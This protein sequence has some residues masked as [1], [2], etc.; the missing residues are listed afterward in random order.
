MMSAGA[1]GPEWP[2]NRENDPVGDE[3]AVPL[4][5]GCTEAGTENEASVSLFG[6]DNSTDTRVSDNVNEFGVLKFENDETSPDDASGG[7]LEN[8]HSHSVS[9]KNGNGE[10]STDARDGKYA[11]KKAK[12]AVAD[13]DLILSE[14]DHFAAKG[15]SEAVG[16]GYEIGDMVWGKVKS[17]PWWPGHIYDEALAS[18]S[19]QRSKREGHVLVA[20]YGDSSYG[21]F[22]LEELV[23][24][25][26][27]FA[28]KSWQTSS[29]AFVKAVEE[30]VDDLS[31]R[32]G[33]GLAC[34]CRNE[35][36]FG[37][38]KK[39]G[40]FVVDV[41]DSEPGVFSLRQIKKARDDFRPKKML[42]YVLQMALTP[43]TDQHW[44]IDFIKNKSTVL[45]C[46]K[47]L[48][49]EFDETYAQ[50]FG[51]VPERP[52]RPTRP[53][54]V[55]P[56]KVS[57]EKCI[58]YYERENWK[59]A[60]YCFEGHMTMHE[61]CG[62]GAAD[63]PLSGRL[64]FADTLGKDKQQFIKPSKTKDQLE[65]DKYLFVRRD[66][67][68]HVNSKKT[69]FSVQSETGGV[70]PFEGPRKSV[71]VQINTKRQIGELSEANVTVKQ[72]KKKKRKIEIQ[73]VGSAK[74]VRTPLATNS[75][76][77]GAVE[78]VSSEKILDDRK[79]DFAVN[80]SISPSEAQKSAI[81]LPFLVRE[82][83]TL[84]LDSRHGAERDSSSSILSVFLKYRSLVFK[85]SLASLPRT[86]NETIE[87][88]HATTQQPPFHGPIDNK[89]N[90]KMITKLAR[91]SPR[92]I[93]DPTKGGKKR[94]PSE[95][96]VTI[97]NSNNNIKRMKISG[98]SED[99]ERKTIKKR[100]IITTDDSKFHTKETVARNFPPKVMKV[101]SKKRAGESKTN[102]NSNSNPTMLVMRF[103]AG[104]ALPSGPQLRAKFARFGPLDLDATRVF[105]KTY[106]CRLVY[107]RRADAEDALDF[108]LGSENLFGSTN[109]RC[110]VKEVGIEPPAEP[111]PPV[112]VKKEGGAQRATAAE[113]SIQPKS[114]LKKVV[115]GDEGKIG[116]NGSSKGTR[117]KFVLSGKAQEQ[118]LTSLPVGSSSSH[119]NNNS[120][121]SMD[122]ASSSSSSGDKN[123]PK[124]LP[125][126][127]TVVTRQFENFAMNVISGEPLSN[128]TSLDKPPPP[129][130]DI[131]Q[132]LL[133]LMAKCSDAVN[134]V[135]GVLGYM[136]YHT[137]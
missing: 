77:K 39:E 37:P 121:S 40:Y 91:P 69:S 16:V 98:G 87:A 137:L 15:S 104:S 66:A 136:P 60:L 129:S 111:E 42:S 84:A 126:S 32:R 115:S 113:K 97:K 114:I 105:W 56:S 59:S 100:I 54:A 75:D 18:H 14:F 5:S 33:L 88:P 117:V 38:S 74:I 92:P 17:H 46:R 8:Q 36:N 81:D 124:F 64:V 71:G 95:R 65:K 26:E 93:D 49:E 48:F 29:R 122:C 9:R 132:Q 63:A 4:T 3:S 55:D 118:Q 125:N 47:A 135:S 6:A 94:D 43:M 53:I 23:P 68:V 109:V 70:K 7:A 82:L 35:F 76:S 19:V 72:K 52:T 45:A 106:T 79:K 78:K 119:I 34:R 90:D 120:H 130:R 22:E 103:P 112:R 123:W 99:I 13:Y 127:Q 116:I 67:P 80:S 2:S 131:S 86:A 107:R 58:G 27:N 83:R 85:K 50:A 21:W 73:K 51:S 41:G 134:L 25:E 128:N 101:E 62:C 61:Y 31:R 89:T 30:A 57:M 110:H 133:D 1:G 20:F 28:E 108:A 11:G 96:P 44:T 102:S 12:G 24:F 10:E